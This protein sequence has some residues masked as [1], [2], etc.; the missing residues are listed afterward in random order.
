V[1]RIAV[2]GL[3]SFGVGLARELARLGVDVVAV[4]DELSNVD[5]VK[6][7]VHTA[8][9]MDSRNREVLK[10]QRIHEVDCAVVCM[11]EDF[12]AA[13][14]TA[15]HLTDL[16]CPRVLVRGTTRERAEILM[17]LG[18]EVITPGRAAARALALKLVAGGLAEYAPLLG[19]HGIGV[20]VVPE[21]ADGLT[22][23]EHLGP[24]HGGR[25]LAVRRGETAEAEVFVGPSDAQRLK[26]GDQIL[27]LGTEKELIRLGQIRLDRAR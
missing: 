8:I 22:L 10:G 7:E 3:G 18:P 16:G 6:D 26:T 12:E 5:L 20:L 24:K 21:A 4:D 23:A 14:L 17:A 11:G 15:V 19:A 13:E 1:S 25:V 27:V 9:R 2:L